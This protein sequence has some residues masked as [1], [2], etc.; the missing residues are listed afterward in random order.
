MRKK[1]KSQH[2]T[3]RCALGAHLFYQ[4]EK[5]MLFE[6]IKD[7][8]IVAC[9]NNLNCIYSVEQLRDIQKSGFTFRLNGEQ[10]TINE[11]KSIRERGLDL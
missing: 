9:T 3:K 7:D 2:A 5:I 4:K 8:Q 11:V 10:A 1:I 6:V